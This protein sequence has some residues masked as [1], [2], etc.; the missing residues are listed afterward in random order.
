MARPVQ[1]PLWH[2]LYWPHWLGLGVLRVIVL[3]P[4]PLLYRAGLL[5]GR[6]ARRLMPARAAIAARNLELCFPEL[7]A[8]ARERLL[9]EH[10]ESL[11][12]SLFEIPFAWWAGDERVA[13]LAEISGLE[14]LRG[15]TAEGGGVLVLMAHFT[16]VEI[17]G[18]QLSQHAS[19]DV[20]Y[21]KSEHPVVEY[22][23]THYRGAMSTRMIPRENVKTLLRRLRDGHAVWYA[24][25]QNMQRKKS[26]FVKFFGHYASTTP[27]THKLA[28]M[29][30]ARVVPI[31]TV[32]KPKG[33][34]Y[35]IVIEP[36]LEAFPTDD[37]IADTQR[38]NDIIERWVREY[39]AQYLWIHRRFRSRPP[40]EP[41]QIY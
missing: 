36:P 23:Y 41:Q 17:T 20:V 32:R 26:V 15:A 4:Y 25:D 16:S 33:S 11:G 18:R 14:N 28:A 22:V 21:R 38:I 3:L 29:T 10:F 30:G 34:G 8:A 13:R 35:R 9:A 6:L 7:D 1:R 31:M 12:I 27:A 2:P 24:P 40:D 5:T 39:P 19:G 37:P